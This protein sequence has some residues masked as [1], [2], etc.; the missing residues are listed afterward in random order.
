[1]AN[2]KTPGP[3]TY[4]LKP[5]LTRDASQYTFR[6]KLSKTQAD[7]TPGPGAY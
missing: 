7:W 5:R 6:P 2:S 4:N 1:M 3:G